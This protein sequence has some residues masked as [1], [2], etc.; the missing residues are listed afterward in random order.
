MSRRRRWILG[1]GGAVVV[2]VIAAVVFVLV[3][4]PHNVSNPNVQF[5]VTK[6]TTRPATPVHH[7]LFLWPRYGYDAARTR[8]FQVAPSL[9][10]PFHETWQYFDGHTLEF[11]PVIENDR[12]YMLDDSGFASAIDTVHGTRIWRRSLG[13]L[14][15]ASPAIARRQGIVVFVTLSTTGHLPG[16]GHVYGLSARTGRFVWVRSLPAGSES[17]PTVSGNSVYF[18][19]Q[20]GT[21]YSLN[22]S[23]G[24]VQWEF[25]AAAAVKGGPALAG[26]N[27]YFGDYS[28]HVYAIS[29]A[30][31][32]Q[33]WDV[34]TN[35]ADFGFGSGTFYSTPAVAF[36]RVYIGN[37]D[38]DVYSF[39]ART[40]AL[41][42]SMSTG[43]YVYAS[44]AVADVPGIGPTVYTGS[45]SGTFYAFD[46][47]SGAVRWT[48]SATGRIDGSATVLNDVVYFAGE[49]ETT[50]VSAV[51]GKPVFH[52]VDG[53]FS[54][55]IADL[56]HAYLVGWVSV[57]QLT[58]VR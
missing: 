2:L 35:G 10:P 29:A 7:A 42:W 8:D 33:V 9:K 38:G 52:R 15:A 36:G 5:T 48:A 51:T 41:A 53:S 46:A 40:G 31:G 16:G 18:G 30:T 39:S 34:G 49:D 13:S 4:R 23:T 24:A 1:A 44:P 57:Y 6:T 17:S 27:L 12:M 37:T 58:P 22:V 25:H 28:G 26:G 54:P 20:A 47:R 14:A 21:V 19:D 55:I 56:H 3:H 11:P 45:Y 32:R 50:G 43:G